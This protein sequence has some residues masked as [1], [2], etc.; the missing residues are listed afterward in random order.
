MFTSALRTT[1]AHGSRNALSSVRSKTSV[2]IWCVACLIHD[3][4][5]T[6][7]PPRAPPILH[8]L[9]LPHN[10]NISKLPRLTSCAIKIHSGVKTCRVAETR[11]RQLPQVMVS[12]NLR[13]SRESKLTL[14]IHIN[15]MIYRKFGEEYHRALITEEVE[16]FR[17]ITTAGVPDSKL[18]ETSYIQSQMHFDDS[19]ESIADS[20]LEDELQKSADFATAC[21]ESFGESRCNGHAGKRGKSTKH[22]SR[23]KGKFEVRKHR[24]TR[25]IVS[26]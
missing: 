10:E 9:I 7:L 8:L 15:H 12:K 17:E 3:C 1:N 14:E 23:S 22:S 21:P 13:P 4:S 19:V 16:E 24:E 2:V 26:S 18:S 5:L 6:R 11:A 20:D 25:C